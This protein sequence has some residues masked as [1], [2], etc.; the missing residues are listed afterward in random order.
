MCGRAVQTNSALRST[1]SILTDSLRN[2]HN[3]HSNGDDKTARVALPT[4]VI[5]SSTTWSSDDIVHPK[6]HDN[7]NLS[8]GMKS[9]VFCK[10]SCATESGTTIT[11]ATSTT[12]ASLIIM[13][14]KVWGVVPRAGT[15]NSP[16]DD[17][18]G[19]HF[20]NLMF[21]AR[22]DTLYEKKTYRDLAIRGNVRILS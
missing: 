8:P 21:N 1:E 13:R 11:P 6:S 17:G 5:N 10:E 16:L 14:E 12:I 20:S 18:P 2:S 4:P 22:S 3:S 7:L 15:K 9:I 19:Q